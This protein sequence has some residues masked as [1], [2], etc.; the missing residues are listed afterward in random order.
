LICAPSGKAPALLINIGLAAY[1]IKHHAFV[2]DRFLCK[3]V[4]LLELVIL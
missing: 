4:C 2:I 3:L 1:T